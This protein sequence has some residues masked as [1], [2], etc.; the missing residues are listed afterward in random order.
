[1]KIAI[2]FLAIFLNACGNLESRAILEQNSPVATSTN[3]TE[4]IGIEVFGGVFASIVEKNSLLPSTVSKTF[5]TSADNQ[6]QLTIAVYRGLSRKAHDN[7]FLGR[8][9]ISGFKPEL[10]GE[11][12]IQ[13][14]FG[15]SKKEIWIE[16]KDLKNGRNLKIEKV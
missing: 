9:K 14:T 5:S 2:I 15:V 4:D 12:L 7:L 11:P 6:D 1:M 3:L 8:Y 13:V 10:S 16:V